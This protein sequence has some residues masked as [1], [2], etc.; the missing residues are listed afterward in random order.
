MNSYMITN[1]FNLEAMDKL[2]EAY[3]CPRLYQEEI[4]ELKV[5]N[6]SIKLKQ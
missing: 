6:T 3:T 2:P 5:L 1:W 4:E